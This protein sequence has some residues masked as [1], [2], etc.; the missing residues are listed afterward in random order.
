MSIGFS[1]SRLANKSQAAW[2]KLLLI[3]TAGKMRN[4]DHRWLSS[5]AEPEMPKNDKISEFYAEKA[6]LEGRD[7]SAHENDVRTIV[8]TLETLAAAFARTADTRTSKKVIFEVDSAMNL[9][10]RQ[11]ATAKEL[12]NSVGFRVRLSLLMVD[13]LMEQVRNVSSIPDRSYRVQGVVLMAAF[14]VIAHEFSHVAYGHLPPLNDPEM[15]RSDITRA[16]ECDADYRAG[17]TMPALYLS[18]ETRPIVEAFGLIRDRGEFS[19]ACSLGI[20]LLCVVLQSADNRERGYHRPSTRRKV[21][22][23]GLA[24]SLFRQDGDM[25]LFA[26]ASVL[27][28]EKLIRQMPLS[29]PDHRDKMLT[30]DAEDWKAYNEVTVPIMKR[31]LG[32]LERMPTAP[33]QD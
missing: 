33:Q 4:Q 21:L 26:A 17:Q 9:H 14:A 2:Q 31:L 20:L 22:E 13:L 12:P 15:S 23:K 6:R 24:M 19:E 30:E 7:F 28:A 29:A 8:K 3:W 10:V 32:E 16:I 18:E 1:I 11:L 25:A 27:S 5:L